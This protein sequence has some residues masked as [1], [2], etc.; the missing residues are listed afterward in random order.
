[1]IINKI[2]IISFAGL[3]DKIIELSDETNLIYGENEK[4]KSTIQNFIRI[5][6]YGM[7]SKKKQGY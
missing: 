4:G 1:M 2:H 7:N 5:W 6:L 3:K